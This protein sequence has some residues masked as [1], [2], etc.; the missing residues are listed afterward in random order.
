MNKFFT[1]IFCQNS[2]FVKTNTNTDK[3]YIKREVNNQR[4]FSKSTALIMMC[5]FW[6]HF[7]WGQ[8]YWGGTSAQSWTATTG[9]RW[10]TDQMTYATNWSTSSSAVFNLATSSITGATTNFASI[11]ANGDVTVTAGGTLGTNGTNASITVASGKTFDFGGQAISVAAGTAFTKSGVGTLAITGSTYSGGFT[12]NDGTVILRGINGM[13]DGGLLTINGGTIAANATRDLSAKYDLGITV[14]GNFTLG[15]T[16]GLASSTANLTFSNNVSLGAST[17][18][19]TLGGTGTYTLGGII[20][21]SGGLTVDANAAGTLT[22]SG[23]NTYSGGT[24][25]T[26]GTLKLGAAGVLPDAGDVTLN[27]GTLSTNNV[28]GTENAGNLSVTANSTIT[29]SGTTNHSLKFSGTDASWT[30]NINITGWVQGAT[31]GT[32]AT[33]SGKLFIGTSQILTTA[34]LARITF[35]GL[36]AG[37][38]IQLS[39][40]EVVLG[41]KALI[42]PTNYSNI[43]NAHTAAVDGDT[44]R[45]V[46]ST[47]YTKSIIAGTTPT[48]ISKGVVIDGANS[49]VTNSGTSGG[50]T[51]SGAGKNMVMKNITLY[52]FDGTGGGAIKN[53]ASAKLTLDNVTVTDGTGGNYAVA[54]SANTDIL[55]SS[56]SGNRFGGILVDANS[57]IN[58]T[59]T[60]IDCNNINNCVGN[61]GGISIGTTSNSLVVNCTITRG[62]ISN[63]S[64]ISG[65]SGQNGGGVYF[66][67]TTG[68]VLTIDGT[69]LMNNNAGQSGGSIGGGAI[70]ASASSGTQ[71]MNISNAIFDRN[72]S[73]LGGGAIYSSGSTS[74]TLTDCTFRDN[75]SG[76]TSNAAILAGSGSGTLRLIRCLVA[77][78]EEGNGGGV[79]RTSSAITEISS[80]T[81]I[82][83]GAYGVNAT[84]VTT[85]TGNYIA[86]NTTNITGGAGANTGGTAGATFN[87]EGTCPNTCQSVGGPPTF[88][89]GNTI[90]TT[91]TAVCNGSSITLNASNSGTWSSN[92]AGTSTTGSSITVS[93]TTKTIYSVSSGSGCSS[94]YKSV[95][96]VT[97]PTSGSLTGATTVCSDANSGSV[98]LGT[99]T[100]SIT[101][102]QSSTTS[103]FSSGVT[104][105]SNTS[106]TI[107]YSNL[108]QTTYYRAALETVSTQGDVSCTANSASATILVVQ[109]PSTANAGVDKTVN[110]P[111]SVT[112]AANNPTQGTGTWSVVS[113]PNTSTAQF[114]NVNSYNSAFTPTLAGSYTLQ[115]EIAAMAPCSPSVDEMMVFAN[116]ALPVVLLDF[117][118]TI[119]KAQVLLNWTT[120]SEHN[121]KGFE[122]ERSA[123]GRNWSTIG[124]VASQSNTAAEHQY[125]HTDKD[126]LPGA[127]YYRLK[128]VDNN[129]H[130][131]YSSMATVQFGKEGITA[132]ISPNPVKTQLTLSIYTAQTGTARVAIFDHTGQSIVAYGIEIEK[133]ENSTIVNTEKLPTGIY[134]LQINNGTEQTELIKFVKI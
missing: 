31:A 9:T 80:S 4:Y 54:L 26:A 74:T 10:S 61:G 11:T 97:L 108:A 76:G 103:D 134:F 43:A 21:G 47:G 118:A 124:W 89:T 45:L 55:N 30:G 101:N 85:F 82:D 37:Y 100:G 39:T 1:F 48:T 40:G 99:Y 88:N 110:V 116:V 13:G 49:V 78:N 33:A 19:I 63:N 77:S 119:Q 2:F 115:W 27:G 41:P 34:Q 70:Y 20:S 22:L 128:Q 53:T 79:R 46:Y 58:I 122:I 5:L 68:S 8:L 28:A 112:L 51:F 32:S 25:I 83:N 92:P 73:S 93:P 123:D 132:V 56:I 129:G 94:A 105:I 102:W 62:T 52:S 130:F 109:A 12:L 38:A 50:F 7:A 66:V 113:G 72:V 69:T 131:E 90:T 67:C 84:A 36:Y 98:T 42:V 133:G 60:H 81:I 104:D 86:G 75:S 35:G 87:V 64:K 17:R 65:C 57:T 114:A 107:S 15:A 96:V 14:N 127:N 6:G 16:T 29:F 126:P 24:T 3:E 59:D 111:S 95:E 91:T 71:T 121:N 125:Q 117:S 44:I 106:N 18:T 23:A 120:T